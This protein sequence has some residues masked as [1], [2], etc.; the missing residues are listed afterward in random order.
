MEFDGGG[1]TLIESYDI[2]RRADYNTKSFVFDFPQNPTSPPVSNA[3]SEA[4]WD[5]YR[6]S[7]ANMDSLIQRSTQVLKSSTRD[8]G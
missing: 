5:N 1:W 4:R 6:L 7:K 8:G 3:A 2:S